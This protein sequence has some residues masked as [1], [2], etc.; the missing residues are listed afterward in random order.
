MKNYKLKSIIH[1]I[2]YD[3]SCIYNFYFSELVSSTTS[4]LNDYDRW[5]FR[6]KESSKLSKFK[7]KWIIR[8]SLSTISDRWS[9]EVICNLLYSSTVLMFY[10]VIYDAKIAGLFTISLVYA[11]ISIFIFIRDRIKY[12]VYGKFYFPEEHL[13][14]VLI[15]IFIL[16]KNDM[17][18]TYW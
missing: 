18:C 16:K 6:L 7:S 10:Q 11:I 17:V 8:E 14:N 2:R 9:N 5:Y 1:E 12:K 4:A 3:F 13:K 15:N